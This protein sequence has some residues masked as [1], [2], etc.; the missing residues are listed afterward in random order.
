MK[1][2]LRKC[3]LAALTCF[4]F[5]IAFERV[6]S[7]YIESIPVGREGSCFDIK[8]P[9]FKEH[10]QM[11]IALNDMKRKESIVMSVKRIGG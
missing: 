8:Y 5:W 2:N 10:F 9:D 4:C 1:I 11:R 6:H 7:F 3:T